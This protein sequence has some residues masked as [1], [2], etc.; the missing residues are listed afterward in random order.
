MSAIGWPMAAI[1]ARSMTGR[2]TRS[3]HEKV[4]RVLSRKRDPG[5]GAGELR[6]NHDQGRRECDPDCAR[7]P[8]AAPENDR[9]RRGVGG[10]QKKLRHQPRIA[11]DDASFL[12][13]Q[14]RADTCAKSRRGP[15]RGPRIGRRAGRGDRRPREAFAEKDAGERK[16]DGA[17]S[18]PDEN[19]LR[20]A[21]RR[22]HRRPQQAL[23]NADAF[24]RRRKSREDRRAHTLGQ[25]GDD[26]RPKHRRRAD[27]GRRDLAK[28]ARAARPDRQEEAHR[29]NDREARSRE[30]GCKQSGIEREPMRMAP[31][32]GDV[33]ERR[34]QETHRCDG[35]DRN[36]Q[37]AGGK[38][39]MRVGGRGR[40]NSR[41]ER[42]NSVRVNSVIDWPTIHGMMSATPLA[43]IAVTRASAVG[44]VF[45]G[46]EPAGDRPSRGVERH[47][48]EGDQDPQSFRRQ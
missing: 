27:H 17:E 24:R 41:S 2:E 36:R 8:A 9:E 40:I 22:A 10:L 42:P 31:Q 16:D 44:A 20:I 4:R 6:R 45:D 47:E 33:G 12:D 5:Q 14:G 34:Q 23:A 35:A 38:Q 7:R 11:P 21:R 18:C 43:R 19:R 15:R 37:G 29:Q 30:P 26:L 46:D 48:Q 25:H 39:A 32:S 28:Q 13:A 3:G 1:L